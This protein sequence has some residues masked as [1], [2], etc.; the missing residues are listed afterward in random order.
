MT[1]RLVSS[2][3]SFLSAA[4][5]LLPRLDRQVACKSH[6]LIQDRADASSECLGVGMISPSMHKRDRNPRLSRKLRF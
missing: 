5:D 1:F 3:S 4:S 6:A 2:T